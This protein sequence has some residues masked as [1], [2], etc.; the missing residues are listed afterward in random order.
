MTGSTRSCLSDAY[1]RGGGDT[2]LAAAAHETRITTGRRWRLTAL[3]GLLALPGFAGAQGNPPNLDLKAPATIAAGRVLYNQKCAGS[4]HGQD[5]QDGFYGPILAGKAYVEPAYVFVTLITGRPGSAMPSW[6]GR[7]TDD[8][9]WKII[10]FVASLGEQAR[11][12]T[13]K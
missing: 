3:L 8:E 11:G 2:P 4:C 7:L 12:T 5:G 10:A 1:G 9:L 13:T 6:A